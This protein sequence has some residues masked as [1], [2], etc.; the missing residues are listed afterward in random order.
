[1][2]NP[3]SQP[4]YQAVL[5]DTHIVIWLANNDPRGQAAQ[6][7]LKNVDKIYLSCLSILEINM[8]LAT[9]KLKMDE[10]L[11]QLIDDLRLS[12][13]DYTQEQTAAYRIFSPDNKDPFDN[14][15]IATAQREGVPFV[16]A[17]RLI[18]PLSATYPWILAV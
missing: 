7:L 18:T 2:T 8:K 12:I 13:L 1:M 16:T 5:V 14:A 15:L 3:S 9:G 6:L 11:E 17:D 4:Q 10:P